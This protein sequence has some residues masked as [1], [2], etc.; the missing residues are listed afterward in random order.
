MLRSRSDSW[1][2]DGCGC[3]VGSD[4]PRLF[5]P[6]V[7]ID[8]NKENQTSPQWTDNARIN[9]EP[10][11]SR[12]IGCQKADGRRERSTRSSAV[13]RVSTDK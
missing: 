5:W 4:Y 3:S 10:P 1:Q 12:R 7:N 11:Q 8:P 9:C 6:M 2:E 13:R